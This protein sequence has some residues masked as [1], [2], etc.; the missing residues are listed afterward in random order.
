M[1]N[2]RLETVASFINEN[3]KLADIGCDH[4]YLAIL[5][6]KKGVRFLNLIDNKEGPLDSAR[7]NLKIYENQAKIVYSL[8]SGVSMIEEFVDTIAICGMGGELISSILDHD[9][10]KIKK[11]KK[12]ILQ[13]NSKIE[14]LRKYLNDNAFQICDEA[15]VMDNDKIYEI[16]ICRFNANIDLYNEKQ[17][18]FGPFL[19]KRKEPLFIY[20]WSSKLKYYNE[21]I[22]A[23]ELDNEKMVHIKNEIS[24]IEEV[25]N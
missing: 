15:I 4:G 7:N 8:S 2:R 5:A 18:K 21:I 20:K 9:F 11:M 6:L 19:S 16:I 3:D 24:M 25:L 12:I 13:A 1:K 17:I 10:E 23:N 22:N 14:F